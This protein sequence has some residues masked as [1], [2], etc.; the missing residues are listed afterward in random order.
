MANNAEWIYN[1]GASTHFC[2]NKE[3]MQDFKDV[4]DG[5]CVY[6]GDSTTTRV[7]HKGEIF[8]EFTCGKLLSLSDVL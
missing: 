6:M 3:L 4:T 8:L 7:M 1:T 2:A 5:E